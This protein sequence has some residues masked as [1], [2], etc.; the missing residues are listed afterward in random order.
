MQ[1][2]RFVARGLLASVFLYGGWDTLR[3]PEARAQVAKAVGT[4][5]ADLAVRANAALMVGA[6]GLLLLGFVPRLAVSVLAASLIPTTLAGHPFWKKQGADRKQQLVHFLK[7]AATMGG[8]LLVAVDT[9][10]QRL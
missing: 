9:N 10:A 8:L 1:S 6:G 7:N 4:P 3:H 2:V 5:Q